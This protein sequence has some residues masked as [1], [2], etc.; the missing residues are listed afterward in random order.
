MD[1]TLLRWKYKTKVLWDLMMRYCQNGWECVKIVELF[2][3]DTGAWCKGSTPDFESV[4][5]GS[6][7]GAPALYKQRG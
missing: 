6:N 5:L 1:V 3:G 7:P 2:F 4:D